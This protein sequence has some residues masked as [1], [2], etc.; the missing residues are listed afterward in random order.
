MECITL[1]ELHPLNISSSK[2]YVETFSIIISHNVNLHVGPLIFSLSKD[3]FVIGMLIKNQ[4]EMLIL[5][6][7]MIINC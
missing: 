5:N 7:K 2:L 6:V 3:N 4:L 1:K